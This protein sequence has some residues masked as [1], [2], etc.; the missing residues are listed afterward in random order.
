MKIVAV[1]NFTYQNRRRYNINNT[2]GHI[3][4]ANGYNQDKYGDIDFYPYSMNGVNFTGKFA[5]TYPKYW[6]KNLLKLNLP[7]PCCGKQMI[8]LDE[9]KALPAAGVF[10]GACL[11]AVNALEQ[12]EEYMKPVEYNIMQIIKPIA[13]K[14]PE[15]DLQELI[16]LLSFEYESS[17]IASQLT[18]LNELKQA[19]E[20]LTEKDA[21]EL[22]AIIKTAKE[23]ILKK[24]P[25]KFKRKI[26]LND[27][28]EYISRI[29]D[30]ETQSKLR[31]LAEKMPTSEDS[32]SAFIMKYKDRS[33]EEIGERMLMY[34]AATL[35]HITPD[36]QNGEVTIWECQK[37]NNTRSNAPIV[38]QISE[39]P[40]MLDNLRTHIQI[41]IDKSIFLKNHGG[42]EQSKKLLDY[43]KAI[44]DEYLLNIEQ[45]K[46]MAISIENEALEKLEFSEMPISKDFIKE[47]SL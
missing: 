15:I 13:N 46:N 19:G 35:E 7:C 26:F 9:V 34:S 36:S 18:L 20:N 41:L 10:S 24:R 37:C 17:L 38:S 3:V 31:A 30:S 28:N 11:T 16:I 33:P 6:L 47:N 29:D 8:P 43:A 23:F 12:F 44:R 42:N 27:I 21:Q 32:V 25:V 39:N 14:Y 5:E 2:K 45:Y 1:N 40:Q 4:M 22:Q